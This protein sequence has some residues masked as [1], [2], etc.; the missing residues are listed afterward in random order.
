M[1]PTHKPASPVTHW[2]ERLR[3]RSTGGDGGANAGENQRFSRRKQTDIQGFIR[4]DKL[5]TAQGCIVRDT[6]S[7]GA[8][9]HL[10]PSAERLTVDDMP[11]CF[12]LVMLHARD[13]TEV[14]CVVVR[15]M[16]DSVGVRFTSAFRTTAAPA[17]PKPKKAIKIWLG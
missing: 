14:Q 11:D 10:L 3:A 13:R 7:S 2:S 6:S 17:R 9:V 1:E 16:G 8:R 15:R 4:S 12:T 5:S